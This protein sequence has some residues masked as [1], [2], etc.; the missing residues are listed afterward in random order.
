MSLEEKPQIDEIIVKTERENLNNDE[1][2]KIE[3]K[4]VIYYIFHIVLNLN[5]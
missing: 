4:S 2:E 1:I 5:Y 3:V